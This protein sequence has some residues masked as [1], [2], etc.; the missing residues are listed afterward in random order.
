MGER[1]GLWLVVV[2]V[3]EVEVCL[4]ELEEDGALR[5]EPVSSEEA[6]FL[7]H[8]ACGC[9]GFLVRR[10][11]RCGLGEDVDVDADVV[12][13]SSRAGS[14]SPDGDVNSELESMVVEEA[15]GAVAPRACVLLLWAEG[16]SDGSGA[17]AGGGVGAGG[18]ALFLLC[19]IWMGCC[20]CLLPPLM[21][22]LLFSLRRWWVPARTSERAFTRDDDDG[23]RGGDTD[24]CC[25]SSRG[26][27]GCRRAATA[28]CGAAVRCGGR[29]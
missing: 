14:E 15:D 22:L 23:M 8:R 24:C 28:R 16:A 18:S 20:W 12:E 4:P 2:V 29:R 1:A 13:E 10:G 7:L 9:W 17:G 26:I 21:L 3:V 25:A 11:C 19:S 27:A 5:S 6:V